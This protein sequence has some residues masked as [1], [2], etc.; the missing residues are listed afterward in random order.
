MISWPDVV[1]WVNYIFVLHYCYYEARKVP[2]VREV[3]FTLMVRSWLL[4]RCGSGGL[5]WLSVW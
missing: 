5:F 1:Y 3:T 4:G 2:K